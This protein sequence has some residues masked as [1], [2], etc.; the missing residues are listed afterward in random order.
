MKPFNVS[1]M[2]IDC[3]SLEPFFRQECI[4]VEKIA[5]P[6]LQV[7]LLDIWGQLNFNKLCI[8]CYISEI[9]R[10]FRAMVGCFGCTP[11]AI[12]PEAIVMIPSPKTYSLSKKRHSLKIEPSQ[13]RI[14]GLVRKNTI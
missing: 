13:K 2:E 12:E 8:N 11:S 5:H 7:Y 3:N 14:G 10:M 4:V 1:A 9:Q 6:I